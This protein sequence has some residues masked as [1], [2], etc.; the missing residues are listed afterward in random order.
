VCTAIASK[1]PFAPARYAASTKSKLLPT[2]GEKTT[3]AAGSERLIA[4]WDALSSA[5]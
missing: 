5:T 2:S 3:F 1:W 4:A